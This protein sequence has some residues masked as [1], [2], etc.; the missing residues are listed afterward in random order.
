MVDSKG[1]PISRSAA[2]G[3]WTSALFIIGV[4]MAERFSYSGISSN[5]ISY[6][7][8]PLQQSMAAGAANANAWSGT[9]NMLPILGAVVADSCMGRY[10]TVLLSSLLY[11]LGLALLTLSA[12]LLSLGSSDCNPSKGEMSSC[13][14]P[15]P[16]HVI[17]FFFSLYLVAVAQGGHKPCVEAFGADQF[18]NRDPSESKARSSFFNWWSLDHKAEV[19]SVHYHVSTPSEQVDSIHINSLTE[20]EVKGLVGLVP[21][22]LPCLTYGI[23]FAQTQ[24][25]FTKQGN[26]MERDMGF[27]YQIPAASLQ[28]FSSIMVIV[29]VPIYDLIL[30]PIGRMFAGNPSGITML[31]RI[32]IGMVLSA[33][34]MVS[35]GL[36]EVKRL[37]TA[38]DFGLVDMP[39]LPVP[40][41]IWWLVPQYVVFGISEV[42]IMIGMQEF[43]YDQVPCGLRSAGLALYLSVFGIGS[44]LSSF[45][46][47]MIDSFTAKR[48]E[49]W[50]ANNI[51]QAHLDYFFWLLAG[52]NFA[53]CLAYFYFAKS[54]IYKKFRGEVLPM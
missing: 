33:T 19:T 47:S 31:Q 25:L 15:S 16:F 54:Y 29:F 51:N 5:L 35:A 8:G 2:T 17:F 21:I 22:W 4:E 10:R 53:G 39:N 23:V 49:S 28:L 46:I 38:R 34:S 52:L 18:D 1:R 42:F 43:F 45:L 41:S 6:L 44:F 36:V 14:P 20:E 24:T 13:P 11:V 26:T 37:K 7:T 9:A 48:G 40:M 3:G 12:A 27:G 30:V 50:F 32:G